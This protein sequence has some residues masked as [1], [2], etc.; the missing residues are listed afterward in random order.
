M[1]HDSVENRTQRKP[2]VPAERGREAND[3]YAM[4]SRGNNQ[5]YRPV[6]K[7]L[8]NGWTVDTRV[9]VRKNVTVRG[10]SGV[11]CFV[12]DNRP[13]SCRIKLLQSRSPEQSLVCCDGAEYTCKSA[14]G[15][16]RNEQY[17]HV[18]EPRCGV[19]CALFY[20]YC[21]MRE[22]FPCLVRRLSS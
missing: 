21:P 19:P 20:L 3:G 18:G 10:R 17:I 7:A 9:E 4:L 11:V 22:E 12:Y 1:I 15:L 2:I 13:Q 5:I 8:N 14:L 6:L 16:K